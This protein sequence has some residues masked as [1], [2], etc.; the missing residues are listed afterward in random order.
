MHVAQDMAMVWSEAQS[1]AMVVECGRDF[2]EKR[3]EPLLAS[4]HPSPRF[5]A[6]R[7]IFGKRAAPRHD[8]RAGRFSID[9]PAT[10]ERIAIDE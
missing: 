10:R 3:G 6:E 9:R 8:A 2:I 7:V 4:A 5:V 1:A